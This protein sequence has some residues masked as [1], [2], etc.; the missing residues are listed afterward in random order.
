LTQHGKH[1]LTTTGVKRGNLQFQLSISSLVFQQ[2]LRRRI[3]YTV[4][5]TRN[6]GRLTLLAFLASIVMPQPAD[7]KGRGQR[8]SGTETD[9]RPARKKYTLR[10]DAALALD[11]DGPFLGGGDT[12]GELEVV[13]GGIL[14]PISGSQLRW[15]LLAPR[16]RIPASGCN[17][18]LQRRIR[19]SPSSTSPARIGS[20]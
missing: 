19:N 20:G 5:F 13:T 6:L 4:P 11:N 10:W 15:C 16:T 17:S 7:T 9:A 3:S 12:Q 14:I 8:S 2:D 18:N 1:R